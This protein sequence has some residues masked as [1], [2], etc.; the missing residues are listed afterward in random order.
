MKYLTLAL[1]LS[2]TAC[3]STPPPTATTTGKTLAARIEAAPG[4]HNF[5]RVD[6]RLFRGAQPTAQGYLTLK[7][8]GVKTIVNFRSNHDYA[9]EVAAAGMEY[10]R[11]P[12]QADL[13]GSEPPTAEQVKAFFDIVLD[14][15]RTPVYI[16][17]MGGKDRTG[18]LSALYRMEMEGWTTEEAI[19]EMQAFGFHDNYVDLMN[20]VRAYKPGSFNVRR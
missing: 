9:A 3:V 2:L 15:A 18:T 7:Q 4:L 13:F 11:F 16:H 5:A 17:C 6:A 14:P 1:V 8:L 20:F 19:E 10:V 12:I